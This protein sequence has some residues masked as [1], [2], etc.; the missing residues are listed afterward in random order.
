VFPIM[1]GALMMPASGLRF[2]RSDRIDLRLVLSLAVGGIPAVLVA[3]YL[4]KSLP[5][6]ALRWLV[7][8]VVLYTS[9]VMLRAASRPAPAA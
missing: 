5:L 9:F 8:A 3:A 1:A 2:A 6:E 7:A 4:V